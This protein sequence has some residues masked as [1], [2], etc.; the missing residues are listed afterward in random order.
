MFML[1]GPLVYLVLKRDCQYWLADLDGAENEETLLSC[2]QAMT[3]EETHA[4]QDIL[5]PRSEIYFRRIIEEHM[6]VRVELHY[7]RRRLAVVKRF[8]FD[9]LTRENIKFFKHEALILN[10]LKHENI[11]DFYGILVDPPSLG[12]VMH[13]AFK[14]DL[15]KYLALKREELSKRRKGESAVTEGASLPSNSVSNPATPKKK[16]CDH[17]TLISEGFKT[18]ERGD[19][20]PCHALVSNVT[21]VPPRREHVSH[22]PEANGH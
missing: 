9:L 11:I 18:P 5:I 22:Q 21:N 6:D 1:W 15:F 4:M 20:Y 7:W 8:H 17:R 3:W 10:S 14:G 16:N 13:Y 19:S 12:I 2:T